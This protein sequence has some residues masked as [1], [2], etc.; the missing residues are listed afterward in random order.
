MNTKGPHTAE[1]RHRTVH[2]VLK[3][4][5]SPMLVKE[6]ASL[7]DN[8]YQYSEV[9]R[10]INWLSGRG[11][12]NYHKEGGRRKYEVNMKRPLPDGNIFKSS[13]RKVAAMNGHELPP[14]RILV[15]HT[16]IK[17]Q[18]RNIVLALSISEARLLK[19]RLEV[20]LNEHNRS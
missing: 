14:N 10:S 5:S 16:G 1:S 17:I 20:L 7:L 11:Y 6:V 13:Q 2:N 12:L 15:E 19:Q 8:Q 9:N 3:D 4:L 18:V